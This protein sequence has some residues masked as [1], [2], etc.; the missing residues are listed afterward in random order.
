M[1]LKMEGSLISVF[2]SA[3]TGKAQDKEGV[4]KHSQM[5]F[6]VPD[7]NHPLNSAHFFILD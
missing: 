1:L 4:H 3:L 2:V 6:S 7:F 5:D